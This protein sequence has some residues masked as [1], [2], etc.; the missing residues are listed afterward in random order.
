MTAEIDAGL[1]FTASLDGLTRAIGGL[2]DRMDRENRM[3]Q[4]ANQ[5]FRQAPIVINVPLTTGAA[6]LNP[7]TIGPD[8]GYYWSI[9]RLAATG[10]TAG[11]VTVFI[12][13]TAGEPIATFPAPASAVP[14]IS[15]WGKGMQLLHPGSSLA[16]LATGITGTVQLW[17]QA[18]Q[19]ENWLTPWYFGAYGGNP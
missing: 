9:R 7:T 11:T 5:A 8:I 6:N 4:L 3:K 17:G 1:S 15:T 12:D 18:D 19:F 10:F 16:I 13:N 14:V 2:C